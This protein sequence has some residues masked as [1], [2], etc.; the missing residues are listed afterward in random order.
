MLSVCACSSSGSSF[1]SNSNNDK[2]VISQNIQQN[3]EHY[4][5]YNSLTADEKNAYI[6]IYS[7]LEKFNKSTSVIYECDSDREASKFGKRMM[8]LY[9]QIVF[10]QPEMF[11]VDPYNCEVVINQ[12]GSK[13]KVLLEPS[14][15]LEKEDALAKKVQFDQTLD[16]IVANANAKEST[17]E[18]I[19]YV[20]DYIVGNCYYDEEIIET[21]NYKTTL[22]NAYGC[23]I[24]GKTICSGYTL[25]FD[26]IMKRLG[27]VCG[28]EFNNYNDFSVLTG[29]VWNYCKIDNEYYYFDL[30]WNDTGY[31]SDD[32]KEYFDYSYDYFGVTKDELSKSNFTMTSDAPTPLC[33]GIQYNYFVNKGYNIPEYTFDAAKEAILKQSEQNYIALRFDDYAQLLSAESELIKDGKIYTLFPELKK[34]KY[35][36]SKSSLHLYILFAE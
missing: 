35:S 20:H 10:E 3:I 19:L 26:A 29:H 4:P 11:W 31:D 22:I 17:F 16:M 32:F 33:S 15:I 6:E 25:A 8:S 12:M 30:T 1:S 21:E 24:E 7:A 9:R 13:F 27:F 2:Q 14:Y 34:I 5:L 18:K 23:L 28:V 36:I